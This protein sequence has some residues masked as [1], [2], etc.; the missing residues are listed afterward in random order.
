MKNSNTFR[1]L[2]PLFLFA[3][4]FSS[5]DAQGQ[6][7]VEFQTSL[8]DIEIQLFDN[9]RPISVANF[10][11][12]VNRG[13]YAGTIF[14][15]TQS[16]ANGQGIDIV[17]GGGFLTNGSSIPRLA[18]IVNEA[19]SNP[20]PLNTTGTIAFART[21]VLDSAT[22]E[23]FFNASDSPA[24]DAQIF[25]VF[26]EVTQGFDIVTQILNLNTI[27]GDGPGA[28]PFD[29]LPVVDPNNGVAVSNLIVLESASVVSAIPEPASA[30]VLALIGAVGFT[31]RR[32]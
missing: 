16:I 14:H 5:K 19:A 17:Q 23:F 13:D 10:L 25:T 7:I 11:G 29:D 32:R 18:P 31:R 24:L 30:V 20:N 28:G 26:G 6:S 2:I 1:F 12:Y 8:G 15:R 4:C 9:T 27:D 3:I 22:S 21:S